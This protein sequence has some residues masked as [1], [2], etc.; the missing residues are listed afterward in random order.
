MWFQECQEC[1]A[2]WPLSEPH[3]RCVNCGSVNF[4]A[5]DLEYTFHAGRNAEAETGEEEET[6]EESLISEEHPRVEDFIVSA[7]EQLL[8]LTALLERLQAQVTSECSDEALVPII[9][10][11]VS[12]TVDLT[13][14]LG[15]QPFIDRQTASSV[16]GAGIVVQAVETRLQLAASQVDDPSVLRQ[17]I[18]LATGLLR[19]VAMLLYRELADDEYN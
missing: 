17:H 3:D 13:S 1:R 4:Y 12:F 15:D 11:L 14:M 2:K 5:V 9:V 6:D 8:L 19:A 18:K 10:D 7:R 16:S